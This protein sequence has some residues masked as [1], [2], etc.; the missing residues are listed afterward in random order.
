M[1]FG[2]S[3]MRK[4]Q[5]LSSLPQ[6]PD[7]V[8]DT[9]V[10]CDAE[11]SEA[12]EKISQVVEKYPLLGK[13]ILQLANSSIFDLPHKVEHIGSAL[14]L[15]GRRGIKNIA[16]ISA[17]SDIFNKATAK[18]AFNLKLFWWHALK[19]AVIAKRIA[20]RDAYRQPDTAFMCGLLHDIGKLVIWLNL[21]EEHAKRSETCADQNAL[22]L[23]GEM[24]LGITH[25]EV[26]AWVLHRWNLEN[27]AVDAVLYHHE[28]QARV[29]NALSL[30][31]ILY[32]ANALSQASLQKQE[33]ALKTA[34]EMFGLTPS[35]VE[36]VLNQAD[37]E[38]EEVAGLL[39][40]E[41]EVPRAFRRQVPEKG[42]KR[43]EDLAHKLKVACILLK[44]L[45]NLTLASDQEGVFSAFQRGLRTMFD[46]GAA[47]L[48]L[49]DPEK[50][51]L[52]GKMIRENDTL[53]DSDDLSIPMQAKDSLLVRSLHE[54]APLHSF[55]APPESPRA[56]SDEQILRLV[57]REGILCIPLV[58]ANDYVGVVVIGLDE[59]EFGRLSKY[60]DMLTLLSSHAA[61]PFHLDLL[62][63]YRFQ[64][65][66]SESVRTSSAM[67]RKMLHEVNNPLSIIKNYL[68]ILGIKLSKQDIAQDEIRI[69]N[70]EIDRVSIILKELASF[71][72]TTVHPKEAVDV[73]ALVSDLAKIT[74]ES[75]QAESKTELLVDLEPA[76]PMIMADKN[77]LKQ[78]LINL[79]N[80]A[81]EAMPEGGK[82]GI[83]TRYVANLFDD[84]S[85]EVAPQ[86]A[87]R[88]E[89]SVIDEGIGIPEDIVR[90]IFD[91]FISSK[92]RGHP[93]LGLSIVRNI[94]EQLDGTIQCEQ[95]PLGGTI[96]RV[97]L[98]VSSG[99]GA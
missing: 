7:M 30:V 54:G 2:N 74:R 26:G 44:T 78:V 45:Q 9:F 29:I 49:Y 84:R 17:G 22:L 90:R 83:K 66:Q 75:L 34:T 11:D 12:I 3:L 37:S 52:I 64:T 55:H 28:P 82:L 59:A 95:N 47:L 81:I 68:K 65:V 18:T 36:D 19:C 42:L 67:A 73:N 10:A 41:I 15:V 13:K 23:A 27:F 77:S 43:E 20:Q 97:R 6:L 35:D 1:Q 96:F 40:A 93:G 46:V 76:I 69:I 39:E 61:L 38:L 56:I 48:F 89:I 14:E 72:E 94:V 88:V 98:P 86:Y 57:G 53:F 25:S 85:E 51:R 80:N 8:R 87:G 33:G 16:L 91:P 62:K 4:V 60:D 58:A 99:H 70:E 71:S 63:R 79:I 21:P 32:V 5:T 31:R 92:A 24:H 50:N